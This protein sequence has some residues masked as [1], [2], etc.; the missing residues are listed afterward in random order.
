MFQKLEV[1]RTLLPLHT[2][3]DQKPEVQKL[4]FLGAERHNGN[5]KI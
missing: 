5:P 1:L 4:N 2:S 3:E